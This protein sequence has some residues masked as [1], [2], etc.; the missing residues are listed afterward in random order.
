MDDHAAWKDFIERSYINYLKTSFYFRDKALRDSFQEALGQEGAL[1]KGPF[2]ELAYDFER[3]VRASELAARFFPGNAAGVSPALLDGE[4]Y[5][6]QEAAVNSA[7]GDDMNIVVATGTASGKTECFLYPILFDLYRQ[8]LSGELAEPGVRAMIIYPMNALANDQRQRLGALCGKL[9]DAKSDFR[10]TFGQYTGQTPENIRDRHRNG[11]AKQDDRLPGEVVFREEM[12]ANPPNI[13]LTNYSMLEYLLIRPHDSPLFERG[14]HW[15]F[16]A[17]DEA[18]LHRGA[19]GAEMGMLMRRLKRRVSEGGRADPFTCIATSATITSAQTQSARGEVAEFAAALFG[20]PF[21][22][23][24]VIFGKTR[25]QANG[26]A[27]RRRHLFARALESAFLVHESGKDRVALNR[28]ALGQDAAPIEIAL[29]RDCGQHYYIGR[30]SAGKLAEP[31]RD[32]SAAG[33]GVTYF[34]PIDANAASAAATHILC[35]RCAGMASV[36][37]GMACDCRASAAIPVKKCE[38]D[39]SNPDQ[40]KACEF[41]GYTRGGYKDPVQ[42]IVHGSDGPNAVFVT[43]LHQLLNKDRRRVLSFADSRQEA[44]FFAWYA[45]NSYGDIVDRNSILRALTDMPIDGEG[46]SASDLADR[47]RNYWD[48]RP[49]KFRETDTPA[50]K[51]IK[52]MRAVWSEALT[53]D[54]RISLMGVG[55][56]KWFVHIPRDLD[57][58]ASMLC[59]PWA[60]SREEALDA[61]AYLLRLMAERRAVETPDLPG[62]NWDDISEGRPQLSYA[63]AP[64][65]NSKSTRIWGSAQS[66]AVQFLMSAAGVDS[67]AAQD[68]MKEIWRA[69]TQR[70]HGKRKDEKILLRVGNAAFRLNPA[71][72]RIAKPAPSEI[73]AC[74]TCGGVSLV[75]IRRACPRWRCSGALRPADESALRE[76]H[77]RILYE[78]AALPLTF[79]AEEHTAQLDTDEAED[80]QDAFKDGQINLLSSSTTFEVGVDLGELDVVFLRNVPPEAFNY[81]QRVGR[82]GRRDNSP[83]FALTYC[84]RSSHDLH[85]Y[86]NPEQNLIKGG[87]RPPL[88]R[89]ENAKIILRHMTAAALGAFFRQ[90]GNAARFDSVREFIGDSDAAQLADELRDF[91]RGNARLRQSLIAIAPPAAHSAVGLEDGSWID[92]IAGEGSRLHDGI[93]SLLN[94][95]GELRALEIGFAQQG[96]YAS[97]GRIQ[98][99]LKAVLGA[100]ALE[101]LS[102][103]AI[104]PKYGFPV[105][106][107]ELD[108]LGGTSGFAARGI[109][110]QRDLSQAIAEYAPGNKIVANKYVWES[111]GIKIMP[112]KSPPAKYYRYDEGGLFE[113]WNEKP[114]GARGVSQYLT[115]DWGFATEMNYKP[116]EPQRKS[117]RLYATRPFFGGFAGGEAPAESVMRG[118]S[119]TAAAP[120]SLFILSEGR[121]KKG[122]HICLACGRHSDKR[123]RKHRTLYGAPCEGKMGKYSYGYELVTD[124]ARLSFPGLADAADAYSLGYALLLGA[125]E[126]LGAPETD[127]NVALSRE[128]ASAGVSIVLYDNAPGGAGLV[129]RLA[130]D[131]AVFGYALESAARRVAGGCGCDSSCYGCLRSYRNQFVHE[132]LDRARARGFLGDGGGG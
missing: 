51:R 25:P 103:K 63:A 127:L 125:A 27:P 29:C 32:P 6:H 34:M 93:V 52:A 107:V 20:E 11:Q 96:E 45:E 105:D 100:R 132:R 118:V 88:V 82:A 31:I 71:F 115:P 68:L 98:R 49:S 128:R 129:D 78:S 10:F 119:V 95:I 19:R 94:D 64:V 121:G 17:L 61:I 4:L 84:R 111:S 110:L 62:L 37:A 109:A 44:A 18:H 35:R 3:G 1:L 67:E 65:S 108:I 81:T 53:E 85:Y 2:P 23:D 12:R 30:E 123:L 114:E 40:I 42:E 21:S 87:S 26:G 59:K 46:L 13:L 86:E 104:L 69:L 131:D 50:S 130:R 113:Q 38:S 57:P 60:F 22:A 24:S 120:G 8:H 9:A 43:A 80:R 124:V 56:A 72:M 66:A 83:G 54:K 91:C 79:H 102:R 116:V 74:G 106:V 75:N 16:I 76:N 112:G 126:T 101:F 58:P 39:K 77:Y 36:S 41:C 55:L 70:D 92:K 5:A 89:V 47:L 15:R 97:A 73:W 7:F 122:F 14:R 28:T 33:F 117:E 48:S 99:R 90:E